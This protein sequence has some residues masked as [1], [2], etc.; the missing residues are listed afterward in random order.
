MIF[1]FFPRLYRFI[2]KWQLSP[3]L[4]LEH[5]PVHL[6]C[7]LTWPPGLGGPPGRLLCSETGGKGVPERRRSR[8]SARRGWLWA[9]RRLSALGVPGGGG[10]ACARQQ[11]RSTVLQS[12]HCLQ[13]G[14]PPPH[15]SS[16]QLCSCLAGGVGVRAVF[17]VYIFELGEEPNSY[18]PRVPGRPRSL[19]P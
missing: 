14:P 16:L 1:F 8:E 13:P 5:L 7:L 12:S 15:C 3:L 9:G 18:C 17:C 4:P 19:V 6:D 10:H 11:L 2:L